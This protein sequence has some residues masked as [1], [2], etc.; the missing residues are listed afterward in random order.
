MDIKENIHIV[1]EENDNDS[2]FIYVPHFLHVEEQHQAL[3]WLNKIDNFKSNMNYK[4]TKII[5]LQQWYHTNNHY[6]CPEWKKRGYI[7]ERWISHNY[8][9][10]L[11]QLQDKI[12]TY[13]KCLEKH[14]I[15]IP[16]INSC[17]INKYRNGQ[18]KIRAHRDTEESFGKEPTIVG[19]SLGSTRDICFT[20]VIYDGSNRYLSKIDREK[21]DLNFSMRLETGSLFIMAG[22][23]QKYFTH[24]VPESIQDEGVRYSLT[25]RELL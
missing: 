4:R 24:E 18:D 10:T 14:K 2:I 12:Q 13:V 23:S 21:Q 1:P 20:R 17:L 16:N 3:Q 22:S 7:Y 9:N 19:L 15:N 11:L 25:F 6:F 8:N 5:R